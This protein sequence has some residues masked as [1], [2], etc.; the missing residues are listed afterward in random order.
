MILHKGLRGA[1]LLLGPLLVAGCGS[2]E[3]PT[4]GIFQ[5]EH[6]PS[7]RSH[8]APPLPLDGLNGAV[9]AVQLTADGVLVCMTDERVHT[10]GGE[11]PVV[12]AL[13]WSDLQQ[14]YNGAG[15][16]PPA[17]VRLDS[18]L[19]RTV[20]RHPDAHFMLDIKLWAAG[21][22]WPYLEDFSSALIALE[23]DPTAHGRFSVA[24]QV[25]AFLLLLQAKGSTL[26]LYRADADADHAMRRAVTSK[27]S[28]IVVPADAVTR[29]GVK[30]AQG[31]GLRVAVRTGGGMLAEWQAARRHPDQVHQP[32]PME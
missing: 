12:N 15:G 9:L 32:V 31:M 27:Y 19:Q 1:M 4:L 6:M 23:A 25:D 26:P 18:L 11:A 21:D 20:E 13:A 14:R 30:R 22:W 7:M 2:P 29:E 16:S 8:P 17:A 28:G 24:C 3:V 10:S 5:P